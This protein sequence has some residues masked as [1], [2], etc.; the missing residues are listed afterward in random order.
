MTVPLDLLRERRKE[1]GQES[2]VSALLEQRPLLLRGALI[3]AVVLGAAVVSTALVYFRFQY[4]TLQT[5]QLV[6]FEA[7]STQLQ[8]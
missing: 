8:A 5:A 4:V 7:E 1:L 3:G 6:R 2:M